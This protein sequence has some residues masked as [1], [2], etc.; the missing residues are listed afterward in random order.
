[1]EFGLIPEFI[2]RLPVLASINQL[3]REDLITILTEPQERAD[4]AVPA[5]LRLR[6]HRARLRPRLPRRDRRQGD[7]AG[8]RRPRPPLDHRGDADGRPVRAALSPR[9]QQVRRH[10]GDDREGAHARR[11][12]PRRSHRRRPKQASRWTIWAKRPRKV[13][14]PSRLR[15]KERHAV[16]TVALQ[17]AKHLRALSRHDRPVPDGRVIH[18][19]HSGRSH[20]RLSGRHPDEL[21]SSLAAVQHGRVARRQLLT[22]GLHSSRDRWTRRLRA[23]DPRVHRRLRRG[24]SIRR[25]AGGVDGRR[26]GRRR[27]LRA[28]LRLRCSPSWHRAL[29]P[30]CH[31]RHL[32]PRAPA[33]TAAPIPSVAPCFG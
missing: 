33:A 21:I 11:S 23:S 12:S 22:A 13:R 8:D 24:A 15:R 19:H 25:L 14:L 26:P 28:Q 17:S 20:E 3:R 10:P 9:R 4:Q 32:P 29:A 30:R 1:M 6:R 31:R 7:R 2:G 5:P 27:R 16:V 18:P